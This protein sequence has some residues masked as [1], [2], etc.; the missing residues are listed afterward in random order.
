MLKLTDGR[1]F[2]TN[3]PILAI[4][5]QQTQASGEVFK[6]YPFWILLASLEFL[7]S[8]YFDLQ[9][10]IQLD[11]QLKIYGLLIRRGAL[12]TFR[13]SV[14]AKIQLNE[15]SAKGFDDSK[16]NKLSPSA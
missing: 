9:G 3:K 15:L 8:V 13:Q 11:Y 6:N 5:L 2:F 14:R 4:Y 16:N 1:R 10:C 12:S 7:M